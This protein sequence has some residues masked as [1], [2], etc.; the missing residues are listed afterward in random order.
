[1]LVPGSMPNM[2]FDLVNVIK[3]GVR[4]EGFRNLDPAVL[5]IILKKGCHDSWKSKRAS[6]ESMGKLG[7]SVSILIPE[8][9][10]VGLIRLEV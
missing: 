5:L 2:V 8:L 9:Q 3:A 1:M 6:V 10:T 7:L 4:T